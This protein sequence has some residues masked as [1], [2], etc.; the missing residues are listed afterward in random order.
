[1]HCSDSQTMSDLLQ[2]ACM[3]L[4]RDV[5]GC[6]GL[7]E[8]TLRSVPLKNMY[9]LNQKKP[10]DEDLEP[11]VLFGTLPYAI[12][13]DRRGS[14]KKEFQSLKTFF[15]KG[16]LCLALKSRMQVRG[17]CVNSFSSQKQEHAYLC[18]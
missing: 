14:G 1:M 11:V 15:L 5:Q 8:R 4:E 16:D 18:I 7:D 9:G 3:H 10:S 12:D 6:F 13:W 2:G 17:R